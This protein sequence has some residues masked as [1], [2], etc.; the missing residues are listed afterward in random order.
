LGLDKPSEDTS[1]RFGESVG[2][3][4]AFP[5][6]LDALQRLRKYFKLVVLSNTD[7]V[8]FAATNREQLPGIEFDAVLTAQEIGSYK[9]ERRNFEFLLRFVEE[10]WGVGRE[11]VLQTAQSQFHDHVPAKEM[12]I[13]SVW[14]VRPG[15]V[16]GDTGEKGEEIWDWKFDSLEE[17]ADAVE[18]EVK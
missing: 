3:W 17:M 11:Q 13:R 16:M 5:D 7:A 6:T 15:A 14:I 1:R 8:S 18:R 10:E 9:P 2:D 4:P 12:G